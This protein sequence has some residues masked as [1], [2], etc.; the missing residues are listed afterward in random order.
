MRLATITALVSIVL[1]QSNFRKHVADARHENDERR[2]PPRVNGETRLEALRR[3]ETRC[4]SSNGYTYLTNDT[5]R[6][7][8][9]LVQV[10]SEMLRFLKISSDHWRRQAWMVDLVGA[11]MRQCQTW[12]SFAELR[13]MTWNF[14]LTVNRLYLSRNKTWENFR[15][16]WRASLCAAKTPAQFA[17]TVSVLFSHLPRM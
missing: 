15:E 10:R 7:H 12:T 2:S 6:D 5:I 14:E 8:P 9:T 13:L 1:R 16:K 11:L 3:L 4:E 17:S